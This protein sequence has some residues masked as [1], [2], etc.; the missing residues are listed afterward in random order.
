MKTKSTT[1]G[2]IWI[3]APFKHGP[4]LIEKEVPFLFKIMTLE[5]ICEQ[6]EVEFGEMFD[7]K[8][9]KSNDLAIAIIWNGYLAACMDL[10][11]I[12][13]YKYFRTPKYNYQN[14]IVW[15]EFMSQKTRDI[16]MAEVLE[17]LGRLKAGK[18]KRRRMTAA[19]KKK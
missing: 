18:I 19:E 8:K 13:G 7:T 4:F 11:K 5:M 9:V 6:L 2:V 12:S 3:Q 14:A 17:L 15:H 16:Y 1:E 10:Y